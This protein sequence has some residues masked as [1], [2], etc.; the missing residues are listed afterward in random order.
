MMRACGH[1]VSLERGPRRDL[2][3][4]VR[5]LEADSRPRQKGQ[6]MGTI[7]SLC[8]DGGLQGLAAIAAAGAIPQLV[9]LLGTGST[10]AVQLS[11]AASLLKL[12]EVAEH[13]AI[14]AAAGAVP[15]FVQLLG[16]GS[17]PSVQLNA[18]GT[19]AAL[20]ASAETAA[21][22]VAAGA[23]PPLLQ[24][25]DSDSSTTDMLTNTIAALRQLASKNIAAAA[26]I[27]SA[28][29]IPALIVVWGACTNVPTWVRVIL[30]GS[31]VYCFK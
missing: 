25:L 15:P 1:R 6:A 24:M 8:F 30:A 7:E 16:P 21:A 18:A 13:A 5:Q 20:A 2:K 22:I 27:A 9:R 19:L 26:T 4:V 10:A 3:N 12:A 17:N 31:A 28:G 23:I 14:I 11:A 29:A